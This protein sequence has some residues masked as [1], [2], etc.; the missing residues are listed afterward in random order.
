M[1][2]GEMEPFKL[3]NQDE[4]QRPSLWGNQMPTS[5]REQEGL[6][7]PELWTWW[8]SKNQGIKSQ[9][10]PWALADH[11]LIYLMMGSSPPDPRKSLPITGRFL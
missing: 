6:A 3:Q 8:V 2:Q 11:L 7:R 1:N 10:G 5:L 4:P 9:R